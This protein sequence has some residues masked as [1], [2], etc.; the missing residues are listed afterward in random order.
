MATGRTGFEAAPAREPT[1]AFGTVRRGYD[2]A[3]V[4]AHL[5]RVEEQIQVLEARLRDAERERDETRRARDIALDSLERA[6]KEPYD[7]MAGRLADL[8]RTFDAEVAKLRGE[9]D[10]ESARILGEA[11]READR[12]R[13]Q[14]QREETEAHGQAEQRERQAKEDADRIVKQAQ[15]EAGQIESDLVA[16]YGST[17]KELR[18]IR[19]HMQAAVREIDVVLEEHEDEPIVVH[20]DLDAGSSPEEAPAEA[21][22]ATPTPAGSRLEGPRSAG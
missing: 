2:P 20:D 8:M 4:L 14:V 7:S 13:E 10:S 9:A 18:A 6:R 11:K 22:G 5:K 12:I 16:V 3:Q 21:K 19:D 17:L 1:P 15:E